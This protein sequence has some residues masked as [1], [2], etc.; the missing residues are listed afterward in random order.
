MP[1]LPS[2][3]TVFPDDLFQEGRVNQPTERVWWVLHTKPRQEKSLARDIL[4][5]E[6]PFYLPVTARRSLLRGR[7]VY[8]HLPLFSGY[9]FLLADQNERIKALNT[10]RVIRTLTVADQG[11]LWHDLSQVNRLINTGTPIDLEARLVPGAA[12][13]IISGPFA[14][15]RGKI[16]RGASGARFVV[17]VDFLQQGA[18]IL[19]PAS[20]LAVLKTISEEPSAG[21][22]GGAPGLP[23]SAL[24]R[25]G[26]F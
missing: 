22:K 8:S 6:L 2:E 21:G 25:G 9:F 12:V 4:Q 15:L 11:N 23:C 20:T 14:G 5:A 16:I 1:L 19:L 13:E 3:T 26:A 24:P 17:Q 10:K 7:V 18:S